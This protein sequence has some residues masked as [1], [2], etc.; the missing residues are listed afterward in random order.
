[1]KVFRKTKYQLEL[2]NSEGRTICFPSDI[3]P[4]LVDRESHPTGKEE[5]TISRWLVKYENEYQIVDNVTQ[6]SKSTVQIVFDIKV[7]ESI[8]LL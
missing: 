5:L 1:M 8:I 4:V 2:K 6:G 3:D 7:R